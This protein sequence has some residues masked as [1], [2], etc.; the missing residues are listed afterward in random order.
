MKQKKKPNFSRRSFIQNAVF[1]AFA[2]TMGIPLFS[3]QRKETVGAKFHSE[4]KV[5]NNASFD[6]NQVRSQFILAEDRTYFNFGSVGLCP[7]RVIEKVYDSMLYMERKGFSG[8]PLYY[9]S[10][11][12]MSRFF[13]IKKSELAFTRN[14]TEG[15]NTIAR[16]LL[17][18]KGD[19]II[20]SSEEHIG[21]SAPWLALRNDI[22]V[23]IIL[24]DLDLS[25][26]TNFERI[27]SLVTKKTKAICISHVTCT[28][29]M[30][31]P[32]K[33]VI[34]LCRK[35]NIYS[36]IDGAQAVG[37]IPVDISQ[38]NPDFYVA[39]GHK[40][41]MGPKGTGILF[42]NNRIITQYDPHYVGSYSDSK[43]DLKNLTLEYR[44]TAER[45]EYGTRNAPLIL[46]LGEAAKFMEEIGIEVV[47]SRGKELATY[48]RNEISSHP[49]IEVLSP[50]D[51]KYFNSIMTFRI[52]NIDNI[53]FSR[54]LQK[55]H[56]VF[57][58]GIHENNYNALRA[59][60]HIQNSKKEVDRL[61]NLI[62]A[63]A[64][65]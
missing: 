6:W 39:S 64:S 50:S 58:R 12:V 22:G 53:A 42:I 46:G 35:N 26:K 29:G 25:G 44:E 59:S 63:K 23:K 3:F 24:V 48:F 27:K 41:L 60:F 4:S 16:S 18:K 19:E 37:M 56:S 54:K 52:K 51:K 47:S 45:I 49:Q 28:T 55:T 10:R 31:L 11:E 62:L 21:G 43:F 13:N 9:R 30:I 61:V 7:N 17:F 34:E 40:W 20:I 5:A 36:I 38:L 2:L 14:T 33:K 8:H 32:V 15:I 65:E 57:L 1:N